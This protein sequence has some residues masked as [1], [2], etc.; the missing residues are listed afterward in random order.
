VTYHVTFQLPDGSEKT[1]AIDGD[2]HILDAALEAGLDLPHS[3]LQG[4]NPGSITCC[5]GLLT[6]GDGLS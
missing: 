2:R 4:G 1:L 3:C 5:S 6:D